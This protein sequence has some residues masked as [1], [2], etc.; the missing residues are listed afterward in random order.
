MHANGP[1]DVEIRPDAAVTASYGRMVL[2]KQYH[3]PLEATAKGEMLMG[4][5]PQSGTAGYVAFETVTGTLDGHAGTFQ[6]M[7]FGTMQAGKP[8]LRCAV[9]PGSGTGALTGLTGTMTLDRAAD[10]KHTYNLTYSL[11]E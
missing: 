3:G 2:T 7:Q 10:G 11:P 1:F 4:G 9:V 5:N 6:I 8:D